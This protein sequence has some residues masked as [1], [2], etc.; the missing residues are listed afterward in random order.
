M[1]RRRDNN[2]EKRTDRFG[3]KDHGDIKNMDSWKETK[4]HFCQIRNRD[5]NSHEW[6]DHSKRMNEES[7]Q[8]LE[9]STINDHVNETNL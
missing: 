8:Y 7:I 9:E 5:K 1:R 6:E 3:D 2:D 4:N